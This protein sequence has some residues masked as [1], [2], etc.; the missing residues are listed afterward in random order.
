MDKIIV[1]GKKECHHIWEVG[2]CGVVY[3]VE[4]NKMADKKDFKKY[5]IRTFGFA[6]D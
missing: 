4:C 5:K 6:T 3:C 2:R 1:K